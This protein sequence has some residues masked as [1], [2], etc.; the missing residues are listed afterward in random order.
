MS[1][2]S[3]RLKFP[4][5]ASGQA[6]KEA[7]HNEALALADMLMQPVVQSVAPA[8]VPASPQPGQCWIIGT[9]ATGAWAGHDGALA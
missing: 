1:E 4:L 6:Q 7:T 9:G 3:D 5:L 8:S 2:T